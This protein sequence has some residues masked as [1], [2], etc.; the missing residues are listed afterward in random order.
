MKKFMT[1]LLI[2]L[3]LLSVL[4][5][6]WLCFKDMKQ[7]PPQNNS[8]NTTQNNHQGSQ[9]KDT[10]IEG[11]NTSHVHSFGNWSR[12]KESGCKEEGTDERYCYCGEKQTRSI[13]ATG[14]T[15]G[16]WIVDSAATCTSTGSRHRECTKC[17]EILDTEETAVGKH[18]EGTLTTTNEATC[19]TDGQKQT[20]CRDCG[21]TMRTEVIPATGHSYKTS[22]VSPTCT[23]PGG[24]KYTCKYCNNSYIDGNGTEPSGHKLNISGKCESCN[25]DFSVDMKTR[26]GAPTENEKY[27][28][29]YEW[30]DGFLALK[31]EAKNNTGKTI[32]YYS[33]QYVLY[34][35]V[36]DKIYSETKKITGPV[37]PGE[38]LALNIDYWDGG[39][40]SVRIMDEDVIRVEITDIKLEYTDGTT[41]IGPYNYITTN[42]VKNLR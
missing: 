17:F 20:T 41:E 23:E 31:A 27:G 14:H 18:V 39:F 13:A 40:T 4:F 30:S 25:R 21:T 11:I 6:L 33:F 15:P 29:A 22:A 35:A 36:N 37:N 19:T 9:S 8:Q 32:K 10:Q 1:F 28:F 16:D 38:I 7:T 12:A 2:C 3:I 5:A 24:T 42:R 26:I 34:N